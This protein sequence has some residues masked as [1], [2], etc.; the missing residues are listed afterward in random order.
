MD[1]VIAPVEPLVDYNCYSLDNGWDRDSEECS[2]VVFHEG[3][4]D[5]HAALWMW[6]QNVDANPSLASSTG[7]FQIE[8]PSACRNLTNEYRRPLCVLH[9]LWDIVDNPPGDGDGVTTADLSDLVGAFRTYPRY[10]VYPFDNHCANEGNPY[11][12][13]LEPAWAAAEGNNW[14]DFKANAAASPNL[15]ATQLNAI[16]AAMNLGATP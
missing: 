15:T 11:D 12:L 3:F 9:A 10:C 14:K 1:Q 5:V 2:K 16:E 7:P 6:N 4:A 13:S 8:G